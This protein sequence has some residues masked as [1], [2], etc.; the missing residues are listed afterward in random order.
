MFADELFKNTT[1][2]KYC[3]GCSNGCNKFRFSGMV[4]LVVRL[5]DNFRRKMSVSTSEISVP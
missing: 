4:L 3:F 5:V 1:E 2:I